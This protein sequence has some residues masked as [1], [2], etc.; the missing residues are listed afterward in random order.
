MR[1]ATTALVSLL[2]AVALA[3][4]G[5][6]LGAGTAPSGVKLLVTS[7]FGARVLPASGPYVDFSLKS[8]SMNLQAIAP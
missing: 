3:L 6:G 1:R 7:D 5:C 8:C 4:A 2:G